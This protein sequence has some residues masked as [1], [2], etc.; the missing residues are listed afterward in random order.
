MHDDAGSASLFHA[1][2]PFAILLALLVAA[3]GCRRQPAAPPPAATPVVAVL[4]PVEYP[5][6]EYLEYNGWLDSVEMVMIRA[7]V[8]GFLQDINFDEGQE[9]K[10]GDLLFRIDPRET[11]ATLKRAEADRAKAT[12]E[13]TNATSEEA[14]ARR[15]LQSRNLSEEEYQTRVAG[16]DSAAATLKQTEAAVEAASIQVGYTEIRAP[17]DGRISRALVTRGNIVGINEPTLLT[18]IV[19]PDPLYVYFDIPERDLVGFR[20]DRVTRGITARSTDVYVGVATEE[21]YPHHG[22]IDFQ[23]NRV[24]TETGTIR[25]RGRIPNPALPPNNTRLLYPGLFARVRVPVAAP[26]PRLAIPEDALL[27]GQEG[28]FVYVVGA[29]DVM[30]KR[31]VVPG[32]IV[33]RAPKN[34]DAA[35]ES[36]GW[37]LEGPPAAAAPAPA[38]AKGD[39]KAGAPAKGAPNKLA[40][41]VLRSVIAVESGLK[42]GDRVVFN[43]IQRVRPGAAAKPEGWKLLRPAV[44][45]PDSPSS[46]KGPPPGSPQ[47]PAKKGGDAP[48]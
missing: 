5:V 12:A 20:H 19:R 1:R 48:R 24:E 44:N 25:I 35:Q 27:T 14:R 21:G 45:T 11:T 18:T 46:Q 10:K 31:T 4:Q 28:R 38:D 7:R 8:Q 16:K 15:L 23:E 2:R 26:Q 36:T 37:K 43:G 13:L 47:G 32:P 3:A 30:E 29:N 33:W 17:I 40:P 41:P 42:A 22:S 9:V 34:G 6:Q 39:D